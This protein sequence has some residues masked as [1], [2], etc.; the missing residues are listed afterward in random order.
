LQSHAK[1]IEE[2]DKVLL[3][4]EKSLKQLKMIH[5]NATKALE[6]EK[7]HNIQK[8]QLQHQKETSDLTKRL[9]QAEMHAK[10]NVNDE[11]DQLLV[12]FEQSQHNHHLQVASLKQSYNE[13]MTRMKQGQQT[14]IKNLL[15]TKPISKLKN[16]TKFTWPP[17]AV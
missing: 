5:E 6:Q 15:G 17:V 2:K 16:N 9:R 10:T 3:Q 1:A 13:Q 7:L 11:L 14:E 12:E 4:H 8:L